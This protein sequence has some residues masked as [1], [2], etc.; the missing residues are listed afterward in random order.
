[1]SHYSPP[2]KFVGES[3]ESGFTELLSW[4]GIFGW[5]CYRNKIAPGRFELPSTGLFAGIFFL[6]EVLFPPERK[7]PFKARYPWPLSCLFLMI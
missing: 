2:N 1:V 7:S 4:F 6:V 5:W 3:K